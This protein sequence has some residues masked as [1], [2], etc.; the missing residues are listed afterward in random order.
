MSYFF[1][2]NLFGKMF[3]KLGTV[4]GLNG[5]NRERKNQFHFVQKVFSGIATMTSI[6]PSERKSAMQIYKSDD[7]SFGSR[8]SYF[9]GIHSN[10][11]SG[12]VWFHPFG[13]SVLFGSFYR[14]YLAKMRY[15]SGECSHSSIILDY[16][17]DG[18]RTGTF[19]IV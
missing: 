4:V 6:R 15:L 2:F 10:Y 17:S 13:F 5:L 19:Q 1:F 16:S 11:L 12:K 3:G 18:A 14:F 7:I 9:N 8:M